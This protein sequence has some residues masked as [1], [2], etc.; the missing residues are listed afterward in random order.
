MSRKPILCLDF[1]GVLHSYVS[2]WNCAACIPDPPVPG[3][4]AFLVEAVEHFQVA[5]F[6]ARSG[7]EGG[8]LAIK[9]WLREQLTTHFQNGPLADDLLA[10]I[11]F[12][13]RKP[14]A[15][16]TL[17]DRALTFSGTFPAVADLLAFKPWSPSA[18][19]FPFPSDRPSPGIWEAV[20]LP[21]GGW[22]WHWLGHD[23]D[24]A[25]RRAA[26]P[27]PEKLF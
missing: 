22:G 19:P 17:D 13:T 1:D 12:P 3:A 5:V 7:Q 14:A 8:L 10:R 26:A 23:F 15:F 20:D 2:G 11:D 16:V 27:K 9:D 4:M 6:S 21:G 24:D 25:A 18:R